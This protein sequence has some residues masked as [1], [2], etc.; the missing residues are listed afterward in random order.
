MDPFK[1]FPKKFERVHYPQS[2]MLANAQLKTAV[3][4]LVS[5]MCRV[6]SRNCL[7]RAAIWLVSACQTAHPE[8]QNGTFCNLLNVSWF[9]EPAFVDG[10]NIFMLTAVRACRQA[11]R[12]WAV[13]GCSYKK[14]RP[15]RPLALFLEG[16]G[17]DLRIELA[18]C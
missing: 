13:C 6:A 16:E 1:L 3:A 11:Q 2:A 4:F 9:T 14:M 7:F 18:I 15:C 8:G 17:G 12:V 5:R 10:V